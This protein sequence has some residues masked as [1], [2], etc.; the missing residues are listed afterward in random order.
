[1][2]SDIMAILPWAAMLTLTIADITW[3]GTHV[4]Q[5]HQPWRHSVVII[6]LLCL[7]VAWSLV[8]ISAGPA[9]FA[10]RMAMLPYIRLGVLRLSG[11]LGESGRARG[12]E[13]ETAPGDE[14]GAGGVRGMD[15]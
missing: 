9:P 3:H 11:R 15:G 2:D 4:I 6:A 12:G 14:P 5:R 10:P 1:M 13:K 7:G 8:I